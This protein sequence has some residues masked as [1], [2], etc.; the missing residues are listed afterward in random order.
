MAIAIYLEKLTSIGIFS[1]SS[2]VS[3]TFVIGISLFSVADN[4]THKHSSLHL[5]QL[6]IVLLYPG[7]TLVVS[8]E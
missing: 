5:D 2:R 3:F 6:I 8:I 4:L 1:S 7:R